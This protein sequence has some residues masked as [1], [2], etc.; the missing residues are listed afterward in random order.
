MTPK[1]WKILGVAV[2]VV[3]ALTGLT[4]A[5]GLYQLQSF[6][7]AIRESH[8]AGNMPSP[9]EFDGVLRR[10]LVR[11]FWAWPNEGKTLEY[12]LLRDGPTQSGIGYPKFYVWVRV[13]SQGAIEQEGAARLAAES[14][15]FSVTHFVPRNAIVA[16]PQGIYQL[17][18][19][20]VCDRIFAE[21]N[22]DSPTLIGVH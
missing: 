21:I 11:Y 17:F 9:E 5:V 6:M 4:V 15:G 22:R 19:E 20:P 14:G 12:V 2:A 7:S 1:T 10:H 16:D 8:I 13:R 18:P 3:V